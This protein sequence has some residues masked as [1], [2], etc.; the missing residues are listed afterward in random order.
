MRHQPHVSKRTQG[1]SR[2]PPLT[3]QFQNSFVDLLGFQLYLQARS[4]VLL[5][6]LF[7]FSALGAHS[8]WSELDAN[9]RTV[10]LFVFLTL[11]AAVLLALAQLSF[12]L[13][14]LLVHQD[15][16]YRRRRTLELTEHAIFDTTDLTRSEIQWP[17]VHKVVRTSWCLYV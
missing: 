15:K 11:V 3:V 4:P 10:T 13:A 9:Y 7:G 2:P 6:V 17:A 14:W 16:S 8:L 1:P 5:V 12:I